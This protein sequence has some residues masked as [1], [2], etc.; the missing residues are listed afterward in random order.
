LHTILSGEYQIALGADTACGIICTKRQRAPQ[1]WRPRLAQHL[2]IP[3]CRKAFE[4]V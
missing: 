3:F 1:I 2:L 4:L